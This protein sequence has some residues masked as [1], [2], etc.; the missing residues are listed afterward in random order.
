[1]ETLR[2]ALLL[3][4]ALFLV[5][6]PSSSLEAFPVLTRPAG[7]EFV[8][9]RENPPAVRNAAVRP[10]GYRPSPLDLSRVR[11]SASLRKELDCLIFVVIPRSG[12]GDEESRFWF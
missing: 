5:L 7:E 10:L 8:R 6:L 9:F 12:F 1:M 3:C 2:P 11:P 4:A